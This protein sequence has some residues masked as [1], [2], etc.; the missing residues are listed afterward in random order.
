MKKY[1]FL[2]IISLSLISC[3]S[4]Q[5]DM[6][7]MGDAVRSHLRYR[8]ADNST[9]T[10][11]EYL[12]PISYEKIPE[13]DRGKPDEVYLFKVYIKGTWAYQ[14]SYRVFNINDTLRCYFSKNKTF[15]RMDDNNLK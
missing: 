14:D 6:E 4:Y 1:I 12:E 2:M 13:S 8:D 9:V 5:Y 11:I 7:K 15:L 10:K 3:S